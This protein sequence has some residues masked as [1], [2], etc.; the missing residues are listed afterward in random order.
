MNY[1]VVSCDVEQV[2]ITDQVCADVP[3]CGY[4]LYYMCD[5]ND[6]K[7]FRLLKPGEKITVLNDYMSFVAS[8]SPN[9]VYDYDNNSFSGGTTFPIAV[10]AS[11]ASV[12]SNIYENSYEDEVTG[13]WIYYYELS[14][15]YD[16]NDHYFI[17]DK[18]IELTF[19][20]NDDCSII[21]ETETPCAVIFSQSGS[22]VSISYNAVTLDIGDSELF[23]AYANL[24]S[25][26][27][28]A[29]SASSANPQIATAEVYNYSGSDYLKITAV[30]AG[31]TVVTAVF[32]DC[33]LNI[34]ITVRP[35]SWYYGAYEGDEY[36]CHKFEDG[37]HIHPADVCA[38]TVWYGNGNVMPSAS[39]SEAG[40]FEA[41]E[42]TNAQFCDTDIPNVLIL[43]NKLLGA[44]ESSVELTC[45]SE[46]ATILL[47]VDV[48]CGD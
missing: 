12:V 7:N 34:P 47:T 14:W 21:A 22:D 6:Y 2:Q 39:F 19:T 30:S 32:G 26:N 9:L 23:Y 36:T 37:D 15:A 20:V 28:E 13:D 25:D 41:I 16:D 42:M 45:G 33:T 44:A 4:Y 5:S 46:S 27:L 1:A 18:S 8:D 31:S 3:Q 24:S 48:K 11:D 29:T 10:S 43:E 38:I 35:L 17:L 40:T